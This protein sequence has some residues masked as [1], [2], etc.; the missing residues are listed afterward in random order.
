MEL[1]TELGIEFGTH[2][3]PAQLDDLVVTYDQV[4]V[5][6]GV[7]PATFTTLRSH[8]KQAR[9]AL[10]LLRRAVDDAIPL[11]F[12]QTST[13]RILN[14]ILG[15]TVL[16]LVDDAGDP[17]LLESQAAKITITQLQTRVSHAIAWAQGLQ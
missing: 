2:T 14:A 9:L 12:Q 7:P 16:E 11:G 10:F 5:W 15:P 6:I 17:G 3:L 4:C 8:F 13:M 1:C